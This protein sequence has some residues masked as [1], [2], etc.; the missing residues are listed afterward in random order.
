MKRKNATGSSTKLLL[1]VVLGLLVVVVVFL[2][3]LLFGSSTASRGLRSPGVEE[4]A[5]RKWALEQLGVASHSTDEGQIRQTLETQKAYLDQ[6]FMPG[7]PEFA[8]RN[9]ERKSFVASYQ[10]KTDAQE[11][12]KIEY[13][14]IQPMTRRRSCVLVM[15]HGCGHSSKDFCEPSDLCPKCHGL[16]EET[17]YVHTAL[18][19][20]FE[21][22][23]VSSANQVS[24][25]WASSRVVRPDPHMMWNNRDVYGVL[26][27]LKREGILGT[28]VPIV[29]MGASSGGTVLSTLPLVLG[30]CR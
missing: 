3:W 6:N 4:V 25:C 2:A 1:R 9:C 7:A 5:E 24:K 26:Q 29:A 8:L 17:K 12:L 16:A 27:V 11:E 14:H 23:A 28:D 15:F 19:M 20:G 21:V 10:H 13:V 30:K 18:S 22:I